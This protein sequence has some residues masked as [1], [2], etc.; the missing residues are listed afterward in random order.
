MD[1][2]VAAVLWVRREKRLERRFLP[3]EPFGSM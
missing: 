2:G 3:T 1:E